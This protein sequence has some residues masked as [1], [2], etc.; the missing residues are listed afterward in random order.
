[1]YIIKPR[2]ARC[3]SAWFALGRLKQKDQEFEASLG[4]TGSSRPVWTTVSRSV[5]KKKKNIDFKPWLHHQL[6]VNWASNL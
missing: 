1:V 2:E 6:A 3:G 4:Y 5:S